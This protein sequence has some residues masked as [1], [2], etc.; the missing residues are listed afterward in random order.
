MSRSFLFWSAVT[1]VWGVILPANAGGPTPRVSLQHSTDRLIVKLRDDAEPLYPAKLD[2]LSKLAGV[3]LSV[4][5][6]TANGAYVLRT[7]EKVAHA[8]AE[9]LAERLHFRPDVMYAEVDVLLEPQLTPNDSLYSSQ[10]HYFEAAGGIGLPA[11]WDLT[12]GSDAITVAVIDT[13]LAAHADVSGRAVPGYDFISSAAI[14]NDG[15]GRDADASDPGDWVTAA[16]SSSGFFAGC[17]AGN[18]SWHGTHVAGTVA[19][20]TN[21]GLGVSGVN[22]GSKLL[23]V[24]VLGKCGGYLS[25]IADA[26]RWAAG[27]AVAGTPVNANPARVLNLSLGGSG[28][29]SATLQSAVDSVIAAGAVVVAAAGNSASDA[30]NFQ[31]AGCSGVIAVGAT[32]NTGAKANYS[33]FGAA[34]AISAPGSG[35]LSTAN[36]GAF[37]PESDTYLTYSGTSMATPHVTGIVSLMLSVNPSL[38]PAEIRTKLLAS[39]RPFPIGTGND[40][41]IGVCGAGIADARAAVLAASPLAAATISAS[42]TS[43]PPGGTVTATWSGVAMPSPSDWIGLYVPGTAP[44]AYLDWIYVNCSKT[45][46]AAR[47]AG[48]CS[49]VLPASLA[50]GSYELR[51]LANNGYTELARS[52]AFTVTGSSSNVSLSVAPAS[53]AAGGA[54]TANWSGIAAPRPRDWIGVYVP[55]AAATA[56][57][58]WIYVSCSK[59]PVA[60]RS[61]GS[62]PFTLP[63]SLAPGSYELRLLA[64]DGYTQ[65]TVSNVF[66]VTL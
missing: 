48:T 35:V 57:I 21:N 3:S 16:E 14:A 17:G 65:L 62:C 66:T 42:P 6:R 22:W 52:A 44:T 33:N 30:A 4:L 40:C 31:P 39:A 20:T 25:D 8:L 1:A 13:G 19:A 50:S 29:C 60:P 15:D 7:R 10:W 5:R 9:V 2:D 27:L 23:P 51:L 45:A 47:S 64:D 59:T 24:R 56:Y 53:I 26:M 36:T 63:A 54:V 43:I 61:S 34:V 18:S 28:T 32:T 49:F 12:I 11:A 38:T 55:G 41:A 46:S 58:E 37:G